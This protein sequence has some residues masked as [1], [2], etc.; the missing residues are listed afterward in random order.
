[1]K[2]MRWLWVLVVLLCCAGIFAQK[3]D[4]AAKE[5]QR[6]QLLLIESITADSRELRL[7]ENRAIVFAKIGSKLWDLDQERARDMFQ[8]A[9]NELIGAQ[10]AAEAARKT[11][12]QNELLTGQ[13]TRPQV[14]Q[15]I[16]ARDAE[17]AR[18]PRVPQRRNKQKK[19][20]I[21]T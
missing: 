6:R 18:P 13:S 20:G 11:G 8:D 14:L 19:S 15:T 9:V 17:F 5:K 7:A 2:T 10:A 3:E 1:M 16:A 12:Y 4:D 21:R